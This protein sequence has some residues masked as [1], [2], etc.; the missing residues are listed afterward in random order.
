MAH[1]PKI[2]LTHEKGPLFYQQMVIFFQ[3]YDEN[4]CGVHCKGLY[5]MRAY[6]F[7]AN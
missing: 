7:L 1:D 3:G 2:T 6:I 4:V 5:D